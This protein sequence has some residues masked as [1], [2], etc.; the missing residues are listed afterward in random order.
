MIH[1]TFLVNL[2]PETNIFQKMTVDTH[3]T[4]G[5]GSGGGSGDTA[6]NTTDT[7]PSKPSETTLLTP[8]QT[9]FAD[10]KIQ[11]PETD[12]RVVVVQMYR[13]FNS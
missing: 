5:G 2:F 7:L 12:V 11:I 1:N 4:G 9:Y 6:N 3:T 8:A 13:S 10:E